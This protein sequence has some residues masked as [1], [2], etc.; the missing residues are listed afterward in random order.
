[1]WIC[2]EQVKVIALKV[3]LS[4]LR[5]NN[6]VR[7]YILCKSKVELMFHLSREL[8]CCKGSLRRDQWE[9]LWRESAPDWSA[10]NV[11]KL[12]SSLLT[13]RPN[14]LECLHLAK[15]FQSSLTF[16]GNP[17]SLPEKEASERYSNGVGS[18]FALK[19]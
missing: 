6:Q 19:L 14:K 12:F 16:A 13:T 1:M 17:R 11:K 15:T 9:V 8:T 5:L 2:S 10:Q 4:C 18:G 3:L 7:P